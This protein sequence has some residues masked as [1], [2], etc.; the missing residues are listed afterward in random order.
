M[1]DLLMEYAKKLV[2]IDRLANEMG[3]GVSP[4]CSAFADDIRRILG[5][6]GGHR[7]PT[8]GSDDKAVYQ[9]RFGCGATDGWSHGHFICHD[10]HAW[11]KGADR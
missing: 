1:S 7:C 3:D 11:H 9:C 2:A 5:S 10:P 4:E 6:F 8:C